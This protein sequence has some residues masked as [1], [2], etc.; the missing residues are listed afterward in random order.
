MLLNSNQLIK[1]EIFQLG[2]LNWFFLPRLDLLHQKNMYFFVNEILKCDEFDIL[3]VETFS[4]S[5]DYL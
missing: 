3:S 2:P 5:N 4:L 1:T